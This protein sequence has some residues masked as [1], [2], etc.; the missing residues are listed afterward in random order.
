MK[1]NSYMSFFD[2]FQDLRRLLLRSIISIIFFTCF[3]LINKNFIFDSIIFSPIRSNFISYTLIYKLG[4]FFH[5]QINIA[6]KKIIIQNNQFL[7]QF[8]TYVLVSLI[9]GII[10]SYPFICYELWNFIKPGL[11]LKERKILKN[12]LILSSILLILGLIIG[13]FILSPFAIQFSNTFFISNF[14]KNI[15]SLNDYVILIINSTILMGIL[16]LFPLIPL[17]LSK[18]DLITFQTLKEYRKYAFFLLFIIASAITSGEFITTILIFCP[19]YLLYEL[20]I[21][22]TLIF[23]I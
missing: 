15:F 6:P 4:Y 18:L 11:F 17:F 14:P 2:H 10:L 5:Q 7:G 21:I 8:N 22:I 12:I 20:S 13:Y 1:K 3:V 23:N 16:F 9:G 19:L